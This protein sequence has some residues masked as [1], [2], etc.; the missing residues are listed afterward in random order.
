MTKSLSA[1]IIFLILLISVLWTSW[2]F[3]KGNGMH[4]QNDGASYYSYLPALFIYHD[5]EFKNATEI[6][7]Q[8]GN[9]IPLIGASDGKAI[10]KMTMGVSIMILPFFLIA[11]GIVSLIGGEANGY[12][13]IYL[14]LVHIAALFYFIAALFVLRKILLKYYSEK[15][16]SWSLLAITVGTNLLYYGA[17][18]CTMSH[19]YEFFLFSVFLKLVIRWHESPDTKTSIFLGSVTGL[20]TLIRPTNLLIV[21]IFILYGITNLQTLRERIKNLFQHWKLI[22]WIFIS[23]IIILLPQLI[24]WK[25]VTGMFFYRTYL[26]EYLF[27]DNTHILEGLFSYRKGWFL[28]T[29]IMLLMIP[30]L[31]YLIKRKVPFG[32]GML[33]YLVLTVYVIFSW[34]CW[35][36]G[37]SFSCRAIIE[38][39]A[40]F[41]IP[42]AEFIFQLKKR[43]TKILVYSFIVF[44]ILLNNFQTYQ[45]EVGVLH[46]ESMTKEAYWKIFGK[47]KIPDN[48]IQSLKTPDT[49]FAILGMDERKGELSTFPFLHE[50]DRRIVFLR[51]SNGKYVT[52]EDNY[53]AFIKADADKAG[54]LEEFLLIVFEYNQSFLKSSNGQFV[55]ADNNTSGQLMA[56]RPLA[57]GWELFTFIH[58]GNNRGTFKNFRSDFVGVDASGKIVANTKV[59]S[60]NHIFTIEQK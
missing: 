30:G 15:I 44:C 48:Y 6:V 1:R 52:I 32:K 35:W 43:W 49:Q 50:V 10:P 11:H 40:L 39:Y 4:F 34:W 9:S 59:F 38:S 21:V 33:V 46:F 41:S 22:L 28:Y 2:H 55:S 24:Y 23:T 14:L 31:Y 13:F 58:L 56:N 16:T 25:L 37:A 36:Y 20:I 54:Q 19:V 8:T 18:D 57:A 60:E 12:S 51:A 42:I 5:L 17:I 45:Y 7:K 29:P 47:T 27:F 3:Q 26:G 53:N